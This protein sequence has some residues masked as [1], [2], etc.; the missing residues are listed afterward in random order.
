MSAEASPLSADTVT[1]DDEERRFVCPIE[2][3]GKRFKRKFTLQEHEKTHSGIRPYTCPVPGCHRHFST[4][5]NL[6]RHTFTHTGEKPYACAWE[7]CAKR[8]CTREKLVRHLK[9]HVGLRPYTCSVCAKSFTTSGNLARH[10]KSH[11]PVSQ[12]SGVARTVKLLKKRRVADELATPMAC[13]APLGISMAML[14]EPDTEPVPLSSPSVD[15]ADIEA[16]WLEQDLERLCLPSGETMQSPDSIQ[17][18]PGHAMWNYP[19]VPVPEQSSWSV[20]FLPVST[21]SLSPPS[22]PEVERPYACTV[23]GCEKRFKR[24]FTLQEHLKTHTGIRPYTCPVEGCG[25]HFSTSGNLTRHTLTHNAEKPF[26]CGWEDCAKRFCTREKLVRHLKTH[27]GLR[28]FECS[29]CSKAFTTSGNLARHA[30]SHPE[31]GQVTHQESLLW[32]LPALLVPTKKRRVAEEL[33]VP[34]AAKPPLPHST[35]EIAMAL[36]ESDMWTHLESTITFAP[37]FE[38]Q[39][40]S[41]PPMAWPAFPMD[42]ERPFVCDVE[43]CGKRFKRKFTLQEHLKTHLGL[44]PF[45]C[46]TP[47]CHKRFS[48]SGNLV[49]HS[50]TH[51]TDKSFVC[52]WEA[53]GKRFCSREKLVRHLKTHVGLRPYICHDCRKS[54]TTSGNLTRHQKTQAHNSAPCDD[55][56]VWVDLGR[57]LLQDDVVVKKKYRLAD[58]IACP[59]ACEPPLGL[60]SISLQHYD[61]RFEKNLEQ[62]HLVHCTEMT[63]HRRL[64]RVVIFNFAMHVVGDRPFMCEVDG[65]GKRFKRKFTLQEHIKTHSGLRPFVCP[66]PGCHKRFSTSGNLVRHSYT[67]RADK[68]FVCAWGL[69]GK[70]F[71]SREKLVRHLKT[72]VGLRPH[73]CAECGKTFT[74]PGNLA[75]HAKT[76]DHEDPRGTDEMWVDLNQLLQLDQVSQTFRCNDIWSPAKTL[77][78]LALSSGP[79]TL[80][81]DFDDDRRFAC[82]IPGCT[83]RFKRKFTLQEHEKTHSQLRPFECPQAGCGRIFSTSGNLARHA[84]THSGE[85]PFAC[86]WGGCT[87]AFCTREKLVRHLKTHAGLRPYACKVCTKSFTTSGNLARHTR[88]HPADAVADAIQREAVDAILQALETSSPPAP[89]KKAQR[90]VADE[91][92]T[93]VPWTAPSPPAD[94][95]ALPMP[96]P[97][98]PWTTVWMLG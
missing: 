91:L 88:S 59:I 18:P 10:A 65:C 44:R 62:R 82:S 3:C 11:L 24:K 74:T 48:T 20:C 2:G 71:C 17:Y 27:V 37:P 47:G 34:L 32:E 50:Y 89:V 81:L 67:H 16:M 35:A 92:A 83:K 41:A 1:T 63:R 93:P 13:Q 61:Q 5:G 90:K 58:E 39:C 22:S 96:V 33:A 43:G 78:M 73:A 9:T 23:A 31:Y 36:A 51:R 53:C 60:E 42:A 84:L 95:F 75:R 29:V 8:F 66:S 64:K 7:A 87:K 21:M 26:A 30:K 54:F 85:T 70:R 79:L 12:R 38:P 94:S 80:S 4:S 40:I 52:A 72:H 46:P 86:G 14:D 55:S 57:L 97:W 19:G 28:P 25:R 49:R 45:V 68:P 6:S 56:E 69:C 98:P 15:D 77:R 76:Q